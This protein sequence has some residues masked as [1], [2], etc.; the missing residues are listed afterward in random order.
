VTNHRPQGAI[1]RQCEIIHGRLVGK[2]F[3][4]SGRRSV[5]DPTLLP[6]EQ[7]PQ[8]GPCVD[9]RLG[10]SALRS[11]VSNAWRRSELM[12]ARRGALI[13]TRGAVCAQT[14]QEHGAA[15]FA[16]DA[17]DVKGPQSSHQ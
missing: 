8:P 7:H 4:P 13:R 17:K 16:S 15:K 2:L 11:L 5:F 1:T 6:P 9:A 12:P 14:G 10:L 3:D